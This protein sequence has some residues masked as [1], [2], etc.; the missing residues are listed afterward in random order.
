MTFNVLLKPLSDVIVPPFTSKVTRTAFSVL[1]GTVPSF[2]RRA[3]FSVLFRGLSPLFR[4]I[5]RGEDASRVK[6]IVKQGEELWARCSLLIK[7]DFQLPQP[8]AFLEFG[9]ARFEARVMGVNISEINN[10]SLEYEKFEVNFLTPTLLSVP[11]RGVFLRERGI[12]RRYKLIP[13]LPL[14]LALLVYDLKHIGV[15]VDTTPMRIFRWAYKAI[16]ELDY[17]I[18]PVTVLY[19]IKEGKPAVERGFIGKVVYELLDPNSKYAEVFYFL[20]AYME[21]FGLGK[22]RSIG[23]GHVNIRQLS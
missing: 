4:T 12:K 19:T 23:F 14:A 16:A 21:K 3:S 8:H 2:S 13:D 6:L 22:S 7:E 15:P 1:T 9:G 17:S 5:K 11:G 10:M 20:L 18:K